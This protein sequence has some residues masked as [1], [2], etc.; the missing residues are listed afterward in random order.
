MV[1]QNVFISHKYEEFGDGTGG[2]RVEIEGKDSGE[3]ELI[4][5]L[6]W[7]YGNGEPNQSDREPILLGTHTFHDASYCDLYRSEITG[8]RL[9][10]RVTGPKFDIPIT[11]GRKCTLVDEPGRWIYYDLVNPC[12]PVFCSGDRK[13][14]LITEPS[15]QGKRNSWI[16]VPYSCYYHLYTPEDISFCAKEKGINW[17]HF[18]GDSISREFVGYL[19]SVF[20]EPDTSKF[21]QADV[22]LNGLRITFQAWN[23]IIMEIST[24]ERNI[25]FVEELLNHYNVLRP[26]TSATIESRRYLTYLDEIEVDRPDVFF[27]SPAVAYSLFH[28]QTSVSNMF[29]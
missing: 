29:I 18:T 1:I 10:I 3:Y 24:Q 25:E 13:A 12:V 23:D 27:M 15:W 14:S 26:G 7:I 8:S 16:W 19:M 22:N 11:S 9:R 28:Q 21:Q 17:I 6:Y 4:I 2:Y 5:A 20:N